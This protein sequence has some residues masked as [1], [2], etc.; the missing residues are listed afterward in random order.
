MTEEEA[1]AWLATN[2]HGIRTNKLAVFDAFMKG[3]GKWYA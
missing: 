1:E 2:N 3:E